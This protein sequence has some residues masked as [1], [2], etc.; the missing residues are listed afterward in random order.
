[1]ALALRF[2]PAA[3]NLDDRIDATRG[4][5]RTISMIPQHMMPK[6][7]GPLQDLA[8]DIR[9][10][11]SDLFVGDTQPVCL[12]DLLCEADPDV[13]AVICND[14][15]LSLCFVHRLPL[16]CSSN[17]PSLRCQ[18][19]IG[20]RAAHGRR[21]RRTAARGVN[22]DDPIAVAFDTIDVAPVAQ[23]CLDLINAAGGNPPPCNRGAAFGEGF[24]IGDWRSSAD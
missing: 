7:H 13:P 10:E 2:R 21:D 9:N 24:R 8:R 11:V 3:V 1:M 6:L 16:H 5:F 17:R 15:V 22:V 20:L 4:I 18:K 12:D 23:V 14:P 19:A